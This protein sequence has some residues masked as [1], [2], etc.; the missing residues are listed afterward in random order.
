MSQMN[1]GGFQQQLHSLKDRVNALTSQYSP[2]QAFVAPAAPLPS[3]TRGDAFTAQLRDVRAHLDKMQASFL[4][5]QA[6]TH[7]QPSTGPPGPVE[8][9]LSAQSRMTLPSGPLFWQLFNSLRSDF[10]GLD[11]RVAGLEQ[12]VDALE[13][14]VDRL[15]PDRFTPAASTTSQEESGGVQIAQ[16]PSEDLLS[17]SMAC[18]PEL[19]SEGRN[20]TTGIQA[21]QHHS[22]ISSLQSQAMPAFEW[23]WPSTNYWNEDSLPQYAMPLLRSN[24][25]HSPY[26]ARAMANDST[27]V[28]PDGVAFR[29]REIDRMDDQLRAAQESLKSSEALAAAQ[30]TTMG[31]M[32]SHI[33]TVQAD[34]QRMAAQIAKDALSKKKLESTDRHLRKELDKHTET[35]RTRAEERDSHLQM[36]ADRDFAIRY[37]QERCDQEASMFQ[38][39]IADRD[40]ALQRWEESYNAASDAWRQEHE[41]ANALGSRLDQYRSGRKETEQAI[42]RQERERDQLKDFC[43]HKDAVIVKQERVM[44]RGAQL[45]EERDAEIDRLQRRLKVAEDDMQ[46]EGRQ[47]K[48]MA[49]LLDETQSELERLRSLSGVGGSTADEGNVV[50]HQQ[51]QVTAASTEAVDGRKS[52]EIPGPYPREARHATD[53]PRERRPRSPA[54]SDAS[55]REAART[56][57]PRRRRLRRHESARQLPHRAEDRQHRHER[58]PTPPP[59][60]YHLPER[61]DRRGRFAGDDA[62]AR[63][64]LPDRR[65]ARFLDNAISYRDPPLPAPVTARKMASETDLRS[66]NPGAGRTLSKH[67]SMQELPGARQRLQAYVETEGESDAEREL[68]QGHV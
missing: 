30:D 61:E 13:D 9:E 23:Q 33:A 1:D 18:L 19:C 17:A 56:G 59:R 11:T 50:T 49:R 10:Q 37:W 42:L 46:H 66:T 57:S 55:A 28:Y 39:T 41:R 31:D 65:R 29:D 63:P 21:G 2:R 67:Q 4:D 15:E 26:E 58:R 5:Y 60:V 62:E 32:R 25:P 14:R 24:V 40:R 64:E 51:E 35:L 47:Q 43:E 36:I 34:N 48:R 6:R 3:L 52:L 44:S 27:S 53:R 45:L 20:T 16:K 54:D 12:D 8:V 68:Q 22:R 7:R 38:N